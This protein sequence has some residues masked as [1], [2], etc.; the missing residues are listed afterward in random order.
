MRHGSVSTKQAIAAAQ[1]IKEREYW[2]TKMAGVPGKSHFSYD[3]NETSGRPHQMESMQIKFPD[4]LFNKLMHLSNHYDYT[5]YMILVSGLI[6]LLD[7]YTYGGNRDFIV[8]APIYKQE[9]EGDFINTVLPLRNHLENR[10]TFKELLLQVKD[11]VLEANKYQNFPIQSILELLDM[12]LSGEEFPLFDIAILLENIHNREYLRDIPLNMIFT[13]QRTGTTLEGTVEYNAALYRQSTLERIATH[14]IRVLAEALPGIDAPVSGL[15]ILSEQEKHRL[16]VEFNRPAG[17]YPADKTI[18]YLFAEQVE[19]TPNRIALVGMADKPGTRPGGELQLTFRELAEFTGNLAGHL[20]SRGGRPGHMVGILAERSPEMIIGIIGI[21]KA[22]CAYVP[23][24]PKTPPSRNR[25]VLEDCNIK[26]VLTTAGSREFAAAL[27]DEFELILVSDGMGI[28]GSKPLPQVSADTQAYVIYTSGSTGKPKGVSITHANFSPLIH[29]GYEHLGIGEEDRA[30]QDLSYYFD[31]SVWEIFLCLTRG[32]SLYM[33]SEEIL[34]DPAAHIDFI[35]INQITVLHITPTQWS[36]LVNREHRLK[37]LKYLCIGAEKLTYD[38]AKRSLTLVNETC[39]LFNMYGPTE[40]TIISAVLE[41]QRDKCEDYRQLSSVPIGLPTGN[42]GLY[43][44]NKYMKLC[45]V[46]IPGELYIS[47]DGV[48]AG[49]INNPEMTREHFCLRQPGGS[50]CKNR[51]LDPH[52]NFLLN[53]SYLSYRSY[54]SYRSHMSY[55]SHFYKT[56]DL[57]R[58]LPDGNVEFLGRI[59]HQ[60]KIR[61]FRIELGEI[62]NRLLTH[63][64]VKEAVVID[65]ENAGGEKYLCAYVVPRDREHDT[66]DLKKY[67]STVLPDYMVPAYFQR[68]ASIPLTPNGKLDRKALPLPTMTAGEAYIAPRDEIESKLAGLWSEILGIDKEHISASADFFLLGGHSLK[69]NLLAAKIHQAFNVKIPLMEIFTK[70]ILME[71]AGYIKA[72]CQSSFTLIEPLEKNEYYPLSSAQK[73]LYFLQQMLGEHCAYNLPIALMLA[74]EIHR[75]R[76]TEIFRELIKKHE[77]LRTSFVTVQK[78]PIQKIHDQVEFEI[79]YYR[80]EDKVKVD[81]LEGTRG[82]APLSLPASPAPRSAADLISSFIRPFDLSQ[83]PLL[84]VGLIELPHTPAALP[85]HPSQ[86]G[87]GKE[88]TYIL[89]LDM[90]HIISD[91][92]SLG[93]LIKEFTA[94]YQGKELDRLRVQYKDYVQWQNRKLESPAAFW[95]KEFAGEIPVLEMPTDFVRPQVQS[96]DGSIFNF[97][98]DS[99]DSRLLNAL[100]REAG[101]SLFMVLLAAYNIFLSKVSRQETVVVGTPVAGRRHTDLQ[102]IIGM[103]VNTLPLKNEPSGEKTTREFLK[104]IKAKTLEAFEN[105]DYQYEALVEELPIKRDTSRNP[106]FDTMLVLQNLDIPGL[107]IPGLKMKPVEL[108]HTPAKFDLMLQCYEIDDSLSC[109]FEYCTRLFRKETI[110]RFAAYFQKVVSG[111]VTGPEEKIST[112][113]IISS[114]EKERLLLDFNSTGADYPRHKTIQQLFQEQAERLPD[115]IS[116][117]GTV[118]PGSA[119]R[120]SRSEGTRGLAPLSVSERT[121]ELAPLS[122]LMSITYKEL[123]EKA[124]RLSQVLKEQGITADSVV[125]IMVPHDIRL[126]IGI[127]G[128]LTAG[129]A[130][131]PIDPNIP[132][133]RVYYILKDSKARVLVTTP[134][135]QV[136]V[137]TEDEENSRKPQGL[138]LQ[139]IKVETDHSFAFEPLPSTLTSTSTCR[140]NPANLAYVIYTSGSTGRPKGVAV[141]HSQLVNFIYHMYN[142][143]DRAVDFNDRCLSLTNMM[144]D[145]S[146]WEY[147]LPLSFGAQLVILAEEKRFDVLALAN[148]ILDEEITLIYLPPGLLKEVHQQLKKQQHR[149]KLNKMLVGVEPIRDQVLDAYMELNPGMRIINGY[150]PTETTICAS[151]INYKSHQPTGEIVP[152]GVP[153]T[154]NRIFLL[155]TGDNLVPRGIPGEICISGDGVSRGYLNN[156]ELTAEKYCLR[157]PGGRF[158]KKL[159][160]WTPRKN[161]LLER[162]GGGISHYSSSRFYKSYILYR[163]GDLGRILPDGN[164][165]FLGRRDQQLKIRG[166]RVEPG[167]IENRLLKHS[168]IKQALVL[169]KTDENLGKYLCAYIIADTKL[170][171]ADLK[172]YLAGNLPD[173]M[174]PSYF[175]QLEQLPLT[176]N[177]KVDLKALPEPGI[178]TG[179]TIYIAPRDGVE[180]KLA[181]IWSEVLALDATALPGINDNFF[182]LG[183]HS[184]KATTLVH[185]VNKEF[186]VKINIRDVFLHP[187]IREMA[188]QVKA[189]DKQVYTH[190]VPV[191][192]REYYDLS[193]AQRRLWVVC[194]FEDEST[195]YN[196]PAAYVFSGKFSTEAFTRAM[197]TLLDRHQSL[198]TIFVNINGVPKQQVLEH[199]RFHLEQEDLS[200]EN[201]TTKDEKARQLHITFNNRPFRLDNWP[202]FRFKLLCLEKEK[203]LL[204]FNIHHIITDG[205]SHGIMSNE[206]ITLYNAFLNNRESPLPPL[207]LQ[208]KDYT[209]WH[210]ELVNRGYFKMSR[211]YWLEKFKDKPNGIELPLDHPRKSRQTFNGQTISFGIDHETAQ[212]LR[213]LNRQEDT[214]LFMGLLAW[215]DLFM[216]K[217]TGQ[218]DIIVGSPI[219]GRRDSSLHQVIGFLVNTLVYR[220]QVNPGHSFR[221]LLG[222]IK[223]ETLESYEHQDYPFDLLVNELEL[224][225]DLSQSPLFNVMLAHNNTDA[226]DQALGP[227]GVSLGSYT[228]GDENNMSVFDLIFVVVE[229]RAKM[230]GA[231]MYNTDLFEQPTIERMITNF[232]HLLKQVTENPDQPISR[233]DILEETQYKTVIHT[234]NTTRHPYPPLTLQQLFENQ[235]AQNSDKTAVVSLENSWQEDGASAR[236]THSGAL[237]ITY[238]VLNRQANRLAHYLKDEYQVKPND[239]IGVSMDRTVAMIVV[240][241]GIIKAGAAYLAVDPTY[242]RERVL[243]VLANSSSQR[244]LIDKMR[245]QLFG[246]YP[247]EIIDVTRTWDDILQKPDQNPTCINQPSDVLYVNYTSGSTGT[248]NG[249]MLSHDCLTNLIQWQRQDTTIDC[250]LKCLQFTSINFCV[251]FQEIMGT[252]TSGGQLYLI[253]EIQ[254]QDIDYLMDFLSRNRIENLFLPFSYLNFLFNESDRWNR[255]FNHNL[256]HIITAG[257]QLKIT[258]GLK[259]FLEANPHLQLHNHYGSTEMHVVTSYTL[260]ASTADQTPI[261]PAGKPISNVSIFILGEDFNPVP[262]GVWGELFVKGSSQVLGYI[263]DNTLNAEKLVYHPR[264]SGENNIKLYRSGDI[265]RWLPDGNIELRGRKDFMVKVRGFRIE[266]GEIESKILAI[267]QVRECVVVVK[268]DEKKQKNLYAYISV[269]NIGVDQIKRTISGE[270]PHYMIPQ[271]IVLDSLP[272]MHNGKVDRERLPAPG[273]VAVEEDPVSRVDPARVTTF[274]REGA[275][276]NRIDEGALLSNPEYLE[277][278]LGTYTGLLDQAFVQQDLEV[279]GIEVLYAAEQKEEVKS[280]W[281]EPLVTPPRPQ[282]TDY[283]SIPIP[284]RSL[285]NYNNY[286]KRI[287]LSKAKN[288]I[289]LQ[290]TRGCPYQCLYCHKIWPKRHVYR[291]AENLFQE[292]QMYYNMGVR[293][294]VFVDD[295]FNLNKENST[296]FF[297]ML[298]DHGLEVC[299]FFSNGLRSDL[300]TPD[301]LDL[302]VEAGTVSLALAL[303]TASPRL[304]KLIRKNMNL[305]RL[306]EMLEYLCEKHPQVILELFLMHGFPTE[307]EAEANM[308][309]DF[310]KALKWL[311]FPYLNVLII[312]P[313]TDMAKMAM[314][315]GISAEAIAQSTQKAFHELPATLPFDK[316]FTLNYQAEF[317]NHYLLSKQRLLHKLPY[318]M[319][320]LTED[321]IVWKYNDYFPTE[322]KTFDGLLEFIGIKREELNQP[323]CVENS[324]IMVADLDSK[325]KAHFPAAVQPQENPFK[326]LLLDLSTYFTSDRDTLYDGVEA[327][328]GLMYLLTYLNRQLGGKVKG[329]IAK[330]RVDFDNFRELRELVEGFNPHLL[331]IRTLTYYSEF[332]HNTLAVIRHWGIDVP[333]VTGGPYATSDCSTILQDPNVDLVVMSEGEVTFCELVESFIANDYKLPG[334]EVLKKIPGLAFIPGKEKRLPKEPAGEAITGNRLLGTLV[335]PAK[336]SPGPVSLQGPSRIT[337]PAHLKTGRIYSLEMYRTRTA[338]AG[339]NGKVPVQL[340]LVLPAGRGTLRGAAG[341]YL[342]PHTGTEKR[343]ARMWSELLGIDE[344][345]IGTDTNFFEMGGHS[346]KATLMM[347]RIHKE[348]NVKIKLTEIFKYPTLKEIAALISDTG[349]TPFSELERAEKRDF[350]QL[351]Y[352]QRRLW[353]ISQLE[354]DNAAYNMPEWIDFKHKVD[355]EAFKKALYKIMARHESLRTGFKT[356][357][358]TPVQFVISPRQVELPFKRIDLTSLPG[359][360]KQQQLEQ[361]FSRE[362]GTPFDLAQV[363]L[364]RCILVKVAEESFRIVLNMHHIITDGLSQGILARE[365]IAIYEGYVRGIPAELPPVTIQYKDFAHWQDKQLKDPA[366]REWS[367]RFWKKTLEKE[368]NPVALPMD[369]RGDS[370]DRAGA[371]YRFVVDKETKDRLK[372]LARANNTSLFTTLLALFNLLLSRVS[373]QKDILLGIPVSGREHISL[374]HVVGF[375]VN[376]V[377]LDTHVDDDTGFVQFLETVNARL[378]EVFQ[379][380]GYPLEMVLEDLKIKFPSL[381]VFFNMAN[382]DDSKLETD[383]ESMEPYHREEGNEVKFDLIMYVTEYRNGI[384]LRCDYK[385]VLFDPAAISSV[386]TGYLKVIDFFSAGP[387]K[388]I[389]DYQQANRPVK[390]RVFTRN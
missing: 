340:R 271:L 108:E 363:P 82:L 332:F 22:G 240:L 15:D 27:G 17:G 383:L 334:E 60:V 219:A 284:D 245:P 135:L 206:I 377:I 373:G 5:L 237:H 230:Q 275:A 110:E 107:E 307:T 48:A 280:G 156:P 188:R 119:A 338:S 163:T 234:F 189:L 126:I 198:R 165:Q 274:Y 199:P 211:D 376:T 250:T 242:P 23:L 309:M 11:T 62:E 55:M 330:S 162:I 251:S 172:E 221:Q 116:L 379:H 185:Q 113:E 100:A 235:A 10:T 257:E 95:L 361:C 3:F 301:Y 94:L 300:L 382:L 6:V 317:L 209:R 88:P 50:F 210:N 357:D 96:F 213:E 123:H 152:I 252:L 293:R 97:L 316:S 356:I 223:K 265:G 136:K 69:A 321:E 344:N 9:V 283:N 254:R 112:I 369:I 374:Q 201:G 166:Y 319:S 68:L 77:S 255:E 75:E 76:L 159:P 298:I 19:R 148:T 325:I 133:G 74:G 368:L 173:Y 261:P 353:I 197:Q 25:Y 130:Y 18:T 40:A 233:Y 381:N 243:Y 310:L 380:Q 177:G 225:R 145:V 346:L 4:E 312:Y 302:M 186:A 36:Y 289:S 87:K 86:E 207:A 131:L 7:K 157:R 249:A 66:A 390:K 106:L 12:P 56:G 90:H 29:W 49:Y 139:F 140:V 214:T 218:R 226:Q 341:N 336:K 24:N 359:E 118:N 57:C 348:F 270:L 20:G 73:R 287:G 44:L 98:L 320:I 64:S 103:F 101:A 222:N 308:T 142:R 366:V 99:R 59:D 263:N 269:D 297:Q 124:T 109:S 187:T 141:E 176:P 30:L 375:F 137:K 191:E 168:K 247:G 58:W 229:S 2:Q 70:S 352:H 81:D 350:Y 267:P 266:L 217:Y 343:L 71:L 47:G 52:K 227:E 65:R 51:P 61:G 208:Y 360:E 326:I 182:Q 46:N 171:P 79:R 262:I 144:F 281:P 236:A 164:I 311:D 85:S 114:E 372:Q 37:S 72:A 345:F 111:V 355:E 154:N 42:S 33:A 147:F 386:M 129:G 104:E 314:E 389:L 278:V 167:E 220:H 232:N 190:C 179:T 43:I 342:A 365:F 150:G 212:K 203:Y 294:F 84:R 170:E 384:E 256:K 196:L 258:A 329:K 80:V 121:K 26:L 45:P 175:A 290:A 286:N 125:G 358:E 160:P 335:I 318:Q 39:R 174:I 204:F 248:P 28:P 91:G 264:L 349:E 238:D 67:L 1:N 38:L 151:S 322:I 331:G 122:V 241:L 178:G 115:Q 347:S 183:G 367:H 128:I 231:V 354:P 279:T 127:M 313:N 41:I 292:V 364:F 305:D 34:F 32:T 378:L 362:A 304:Q 282:I 239:V 132:A 276:V 53:G 273:T 105:Q 246:D 324:R 337:V 138:S 21:L 169:A 296:R 288:T 272:L 134:K 202:L 285:V 184:L 244:L 306:R 228:Y 253:G 89:M 260:D 385:K 161:F 370:S 149:V 14:F 388:T 158:L 146:V 295:I 327:P 194:H 92:T 181:Q 339:D 180:S 333:V 93:V 200:Q 315:Q 117:I 193:Y 216:Y 13:L 328:L 78:E 268:E 299:M 16:L 120:T 54:I 205:W 192:D 303:E 143:Y 83:A 153:L 259:R 155:D 323:T 371:S 215:F 277:K 63:E 102:P 35:D 224:E 31:W 351:S 387:A 291:S 8:G 195:A